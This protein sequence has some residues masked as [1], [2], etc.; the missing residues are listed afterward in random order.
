MSEPDIERSRGVASSRDGPL[1][2]RAARILLHPPR[3]QACAPGAQAGSTPWSKRADKDTFISP[4]LVS[5]NTT[6]TPPGE[7]N[8]CKKARALPCDTKSQMPFARMPKGQVQ[9]RP[10][11][12]EGAWRSGGKPSGA[13]MKRP[14]LSEDTTL[15]SS[16]DR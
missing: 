11:Q 13:P 6:P 4:V 5:T 16:C 14:R 10:L 12:K 2:S 15:R 1:G 9:R 7:R 8:R 3:R